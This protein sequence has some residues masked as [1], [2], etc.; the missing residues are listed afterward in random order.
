MMHIDHNFFSQLHMQK[1]LLTKL[2]H[3]VLGANMDVC[4]E[5]MR[6]QAY[7]VQSQERAEERNK[8][9]WCVPLY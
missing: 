4:L 3:L 1:H 9:A 2:E 5:E 7:L 8:P 6:G